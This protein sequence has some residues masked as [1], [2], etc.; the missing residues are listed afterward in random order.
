M[1]LHK[2]GVTILMITHDDRLLYEYPKGY[3]DMRTFRHIRLENGKI[4]NG[5][6]KYAEKKD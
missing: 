2:E 1:E 4:R 6:E 5:T 3:A